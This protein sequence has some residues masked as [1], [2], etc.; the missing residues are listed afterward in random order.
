MI[1]IGDLLINS[2]SI[3][4]K[5]LVGYVVRHD[6]INQLNDLVDSKD[7]RLIQITGETGVGKQ[8]NWVHGWKKDMLMCLSFIFI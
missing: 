1:V 6:F 2:R 3:L 4:Y 5:V 7:H 8:H